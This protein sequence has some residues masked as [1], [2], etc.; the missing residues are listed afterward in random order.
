VVQRGSTVDIPTPDAAHVKTA[1]L[2]KTATATHVTTVDMRSVALD[3]RPGP[4]G[5]SVTVPKES[6]IA[7]PGP[8]MLFLVDDRGVPS[9]A[10]IVQVP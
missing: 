6:T 3:V 10:K 2:I 1:R 8:Y 9:E 7:P 4:D 5:V